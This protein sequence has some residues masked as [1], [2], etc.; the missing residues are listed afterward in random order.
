MKSGKQQKHTHTKQHLYALC[1]HLRLCAH[2]AIARVYGFIPQIGG[3]IL[4]ALSL[5]VYRD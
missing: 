2:A 4:S 5:P 1:N 3:F